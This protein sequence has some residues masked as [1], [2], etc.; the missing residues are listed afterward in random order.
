MTLLIRLVAKY[1]LWIYVLCGIGMMLYLRSALVARKEGGQAVYSLERESAASRIYRSS[2]MILL[3]LLIAVGVY[4]LSHYVELPSPA[5]S[6]IAVPTV[7]TGT[8]APTQRTPTLTP[9]APTL[10]ILPTSTRRPRSTAATVPTTAPNTPATAVAPASCPD[11]NVQIVQPGRGQTINEGIQVRGTAQKDQF[12]RYEFKF[13]SQD[14][15]DEWHWVETF[16]TPVSGGELGFWKTSHLPSGSYLFMLIAIDHMGNSQE[17]I[18]P[19][20]VK[21]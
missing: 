18:V 2:G 21:H 15:A 4:A 17:C 13:K 7:A 12:D 8:P 6:P 5:A 14:V 1:A 10:T 19:V 16:R 9:G 3:L 20:V 11:P